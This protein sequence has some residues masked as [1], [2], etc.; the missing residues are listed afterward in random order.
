MYTWYLSVAVVGK[1]VNA[2]LNILDDV[3][4][5]QLLNAL[6]HGSR[7]IEVLKSSEVEGQADNVGSG[8]G[9]TRD[10]VGGRGG[11]NPGGKDILTGGEDVNDLAKVG[12]TG[13]A[14][15]LVD[16]GNSEGI[17]GRGRAGLAGIRL[18]E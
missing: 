17:G 2:A 3:L 8:H 15:A 9:G 14:V 11:A 5:G 13:A 6:G 7:A 10:G 1:Q 4:G 18:R 12:E 16:S